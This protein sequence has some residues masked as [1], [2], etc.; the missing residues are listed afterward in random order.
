M[1]Q[2]SH[3]K[4]G[5]FDLNDDE[6]ELTHYGQSLAEIEKFEQPESDSDDDDLGKIEGEMS[7]QKP[8]VSSMYN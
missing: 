8:D 4:P 3:E 5:M 1:L 2:K 7:L 6:E